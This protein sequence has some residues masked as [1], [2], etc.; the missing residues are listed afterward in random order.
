MEN[1]VKTNLLEFKERAYYLL[2]IQMPEYPSGY[3]KEKVR[4][5]FI[6]NIARKLTKILG[7]SDIIGRRKAKSIATN[8]LN[9]NMKKQIR[10]Q[11]DMLTAIWIS[12]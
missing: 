11:L 12:S 1:S 7:I 4:N 3:N 6:G 5:E 2:T 10:M 9:T 8:N